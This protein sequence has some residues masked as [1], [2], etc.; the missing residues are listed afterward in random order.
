MLPRYHSV[1]YLLQFHPDVLPLRVPPERY[2]I[3]DA[4]DDYTAHLFSFQ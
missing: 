4:D 1:F 3:G 2:P